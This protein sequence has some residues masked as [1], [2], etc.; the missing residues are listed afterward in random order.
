[1]NII[2]IETYEVFKNLIG[3]LNIIQQRL[4]ADMAYI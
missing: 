2:S 1:M 4:L 3:L